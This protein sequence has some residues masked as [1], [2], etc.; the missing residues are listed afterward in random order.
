MKPTALIAED[1]PLLAA[2]LARE[3]TAL[4]PELHIAASVGDGASAVKESLARLPDVL[5]FDVR[6]PGLDGLDAASD[7]LD[8]W[9]LD[10]RALPQLVFVTAYDEYAVRAFEHAACDYLV[11]PVQRE[12]LAQCVSRLKLRLT[13]QAQSLQH[14]SFSDE[15]RQFARIQ[16][17]QDA[18]ESIAPESASEAQL[19]GLGELQRAHFKAHPAAPSSAAPLPPLQRITA[20]VGTSLVIVPIEDVLYFEAADKYVRVITADKELLIR[21]P[22][23]DLLPQLAQ[24]DFVQIHR[25]TLVRQSAIRRILRSEDGKL[26]VELAERTEQLTISRLYAHLF[27]AM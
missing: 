13:E 25:A 24:S 14:A 10:E 9:P 19:R 18:I 2:S 20:S 27:K 12:R 22:I 4:W 6:M 11:K 26:R 8:A 7:I 15:K 1:E 5:F 16:S 21:T 3:L 17:A 23:K